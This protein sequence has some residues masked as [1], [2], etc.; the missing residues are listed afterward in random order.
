MKVKFWLVSPVKHLVRVFS[1]M[2]SCLEGR[3]V[4]L[5]S[6]A[7][8]PCFFYRCLSEWFVWDNK[9][10]K[11]T[12]HCLQ[13]CGTPCSNPIAAQSTPIPN[14]FFSLTEISGLRGLDLTDPTWSP[15]GLRVKM[16][17]QGEEEAQ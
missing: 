17:V 14:F 15:S 12:H 4:I 5:F 2:F 3:D 7:T 10:I 13:H 8:Y 9:H 1:L 16:L 11:G 6:S